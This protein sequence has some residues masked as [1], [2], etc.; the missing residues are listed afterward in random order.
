MTTPKQK[1]DSKL[2]RPISKKTLAEEVVVILKRF[3]LTEKLKE[4]DKLPPERELAT[5]LGVSHRVVREALSILAGQ[6]VI[7]KEHG[8]GAFVRAFDANRLQAEQAAFFLSSS[9]IAEFYKLRRAIEVG[10]ICLAV[11]RATEEDLTELGEI[12]EVMGP[13]AERGE[14]IMA[15]EMRFHLTLLRATHEEVFH[16]LDY[17]IA[18]AIRLKAY[19]NPRRLYRSAKIPSTMV[20][21]QAIVDAVRQRDGVRAV[22]E[23][24]KHFDTM[25]R[26]IGF[27]EK[28]GQNLKKGRPNPTGN[29]EP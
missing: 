4:G 6:G 2:L 9:N 11:E 14:S 3:I 24:Y 26:S 23:M 22:S 28:L 20:E 13:K 29:P 21:H 19:D 5:T 16:Q 8:R 12:L 15:E 18:E 7:G 27:A 17:L 25:M 1:S 10:A